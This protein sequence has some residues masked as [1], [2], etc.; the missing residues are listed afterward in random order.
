MRAHRIRTVFA[1]VLG[2][3]FMVGCQPNCRSIEFA[4]PE[5]AE[6]VL[7]YPFRASYELSQGYCNPLGG[8]SNRLAYDFAMPLGDPIVAA[9]GGVVTEVVS[10]FRDG[11]LQRGHNNRLLIRHADG[12][13]AWYAHLQQESILVEVGDTVVQGQPVAS[14]GNSGN[15]GNLPHLHFEVFAGVPYDYADA[16]PVTFRNVIGRDY[17]RGALVWRRRYEA[18]PV[19]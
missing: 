1:L 6:Y 16:I 9:R 14:C 8:H 4:S 2:G 13:V 17:E 5:S 11:D 10:H 18:G 3:L 15:T 7:P 12:S 19:D